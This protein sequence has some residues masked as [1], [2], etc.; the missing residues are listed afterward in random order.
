MK[1]FQ[2]QPQA[3]HQARTS[4]DE[5]IVALE[6]DFVTKRDIHSDY[7]FT[8]ADQNVTGVER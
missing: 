7:D 2:S 1:N 3:S 5:I 6:A 8:I 4:C